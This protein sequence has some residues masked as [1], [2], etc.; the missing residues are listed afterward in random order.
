M[1]F[2]CRQKSLYT[3]TLI[4]SF[5]T[6]LFSISFLVYLLISGNIS[7]TNIVIIAN[8]IFSPIVI[9]ILNYIVYSGNYTYSI[10]KQS[11][12]MK[13]KII[14]S[15]ILL[16]SLFTLAGLICTILGV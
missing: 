2:K 3:L 14:I 7:N 9:L 10:L 13:E 1:F 8:V 12:E 6:I 15:F 11:D 4:I 16:I 5:I